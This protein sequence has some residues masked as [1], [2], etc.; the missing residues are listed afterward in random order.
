MIKN[1]NHWITLFYFSVSRHVPVF[2]KEVFL[3]LFFHCGVVG[4]HFGEHDA[5]H[6]ARQLWRLHGAGEIA[7]FGARA[8][9]GDSV[10]E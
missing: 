10:C 3:S 4:R 2:T 6:C 1:Y 7:A 5:L 9:S 8:K